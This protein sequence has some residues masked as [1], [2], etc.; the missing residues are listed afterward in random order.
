MPSTDSS[1]PSDTVSFEGINVAIATPCYGGVLSSAYLSSLA[2]TIPVLL[3]NKIKYYVMTVPNESIVAKARN[4]L[5]DAFLK[6]DGTHL[7]FIDA[8]MGWKPE[9]VLR[10]FATKKS[11]VGAAGPRKQD[12]V[13]FCALL[14]NPA[15]WETATGMVKAISVGTGCMV[16]A[17]EVFEKMKESDPDNWYW[18]GSAENKIYNFFEN[19]IYKNHLWTEDYNFCNKWRGLKGEIWVDPGFF[20]EHIGQKTWSGTLGEVLKPMSQYFIHPTL[21]E[22]ITDDK[23]PK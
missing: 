10:L 17:R 23:H 21:V 8:D 5:V 13:S 20:L 14:E 16:I 11:I 12:S 6:S 9:Q 18:D 4:T 3:A 15:V 7:W 22:G 19:R 2:F 1:K